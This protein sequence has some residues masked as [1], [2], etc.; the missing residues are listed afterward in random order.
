MVAKIIEIMHPGK[1]G[2]AI[3]ADLLAQGHHVP[4]SSAGRSD[5]TGRRSRDAGLD[6]VAGVAD[7]SAR[8]EVIISVCPP[9]AALDVAGQISEFSGIFVEANAVS[10]ATVNEIADIMRPTGAAVVDGGIMGAPP[11]APDEISRYQI[12][13]SGDEAHTIAAL[14]DGG[15]IRASVIDG[16]VGAA[17]AL[18][19]AWAAWIK[20]SSALLLAIRA[21]ARAYHIEDE[22][23]AEWTRG[24]PGLAERSDEAARLLAEKGWRWP[25]EMEEIAITA[26]AAGVNEA[27]FLGAADVFRQAAQAVEPPSRRRPPA[28]SAT[29]TF[30]HSSTPLSTLYVPLCS[31][32]SARWRPARSAPPSA[33]A[34]RWRARTQRTG[35]RQPR[36]PCSR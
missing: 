29:S 26:R 8:C 12:F 13:L 32:A 19:M 34:G 27:M 28:N 17:S 9:H 15:K 10:P 6:E 1:M 30:R 3:G 24:I 31:S 20:G 33:G 25:G 22:V 21:F 7:L 14:F 36:F 16:P 2:S 11:G 5:A 23:L 35:R 18:K 4:W